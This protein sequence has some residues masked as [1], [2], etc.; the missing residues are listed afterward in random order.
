MSEERTNERAMFKHTGVPHIALFLLIPIEF[1]GMCCFLAYVLSHWHDFIGQSTAL[2]S[3]LAW[4]MALVLYMGLAWL[5][6]KVLRGAIEAVMVLVHGVADVYHKLGESRIAHA[7]RVLL[8]TDANYVVH[9]DCGKVIVTPIAQE[10]HSYSHR[11]LGQADIDRTQIAIDVLSL[12]QGQKE[13]PTNVR[14]EDIRHQVPQGHVL[15]GIGHTGIETKERAVG[16]CVWIVGLS[17]TGKTSTTVLRVEERRADGHK[18]LGV[19]PHFFK[20]D[21]LTNAVA[22]YAGDFL[23]PMAR[24]PEE[25]AAVFNAFLDEFNARKAGRVPKPWQNITLLVDE[26]TAIMDPTTKQEEENAKLLPTIARVCGQEA[27]NFEM[28]GIFISQQATGL[29]WLRKMALMII[30]HQLLMESEKKLA[31]NGD[32]EAVED[33]KSWPVGRTY[34]YGVGFTD[35]PRT[36]Q[37]PYFARTV[38]ADRASYARMEPLQPCQKP[39]TEEVE[40]IDLQGAVTA[41][42]GGATG[43]RPLMRS[44]NTTYYKASQLYQ[45]MKVKGLIQ[46]ID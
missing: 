11:A 18:F 16:A 4:F 14:Y 15:V 38:D 46:V 34:I 30:V 21:S 26:V 6:V 36:V 1:V 39:R 24:T 23:Q 29:A 5:A 44:L 43:V 22:G 32:M 3:W 42:N 17:G 20:P 8:H 2:V 12:P 35:G 28:G 13:L 37:Q 45:E 33:M 19:D 7:Q 27:R 40:A 9:M 10:K 25:T 41:W 31:C